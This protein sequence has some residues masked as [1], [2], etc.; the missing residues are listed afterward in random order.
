MK[1]IKIIA[2]ASAAPANSYDNEKLCTMV[3]SD[4][5]WIETRTGIRNRHI[6]TNENA[7]SLAV[8]A[9]EKLFAKADIDKSRISAVIAATST[10][11]FVFP[12]VAC[13]AAKELGLRR[14]ILAFDLSAACS[15]FMY[16]LET[17]RCYI[18]QNGGMALVIGTEKLSGIIDY[19]DR[20]TCILFGDGAGAA[21]IESS[22]KLYHHVSGC[23]ADIRALSL[24]GPGDGDRFVHMDGHRVFRF[25]VSILKEVVDKLLSDTGLTIS[26]VNYVICHQANARIIDAVKKKYPG[27]EHKFYMN[28]EEYGNTSAASIPLLL[29]EMF[30]KG[31][32]QEGMKVICAGFGAGLTWGGTLLEI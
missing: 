18:A 15:G 21:L 3:D 12:S 6:C 4:P 25:A 26:E 1:G 29:S 31:L 11:E 10:P 17:A 19:T 14:E 27:Q 23:E 13:M 16:A 7:V 5:E 32:L 30:E 28:L 8:E 24:K 22:D 2:T 9:G 20:S